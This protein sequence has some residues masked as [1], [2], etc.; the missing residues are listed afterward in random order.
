[1]RGSHQPGRAPGA[2][3]KQ[4]QLQLLFCCSCQTGTS[5]A[6]LSMVESP[7]LCNV[8]LAAALPALLSCQT[9]PGR[10]P[11]VNLPAACMWLQSLLLAQT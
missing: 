2:S 7:A 8:S 4:V 10:Q 11:N 5:L 3:K 6:T 9:G 1:M